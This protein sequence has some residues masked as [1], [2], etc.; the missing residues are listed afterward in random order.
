MKEG[1][2]ACIYKMCV[3]AKGGGG[4]SGRVYSLRAM[5]FNLSK[6][7]ARTCE[8]VCRWLKEGERACIYK[9]C[10]CVCM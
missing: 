10:V 3:C 8:C 4:G 9:M 7:N 6:T 1:E 2:R 5:R